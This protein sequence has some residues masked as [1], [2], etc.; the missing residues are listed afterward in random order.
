LVVRLLVVSKS[1]RRHSALRQVFK[2]RHNPSERAQRTA[3]RILARAASKVCG[4]HP[5]AQRHAN[6]QDSPGRIATEVLMAVLQAKVL[7]ATHLELLEPIA[8]AEGSRVVVS[9]ADADQDDE[10]ASWLEVSLKGLQ[11]AYGDDE[12]DYSLSS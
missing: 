1:A 8:L 4:E 10:H 2:R 12:P 5:G 7:D 3:S 9:V 6:L 11:A